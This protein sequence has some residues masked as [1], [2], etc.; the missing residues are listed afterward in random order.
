MP[1][2]DR[3]LSPPSFAGRVRGRIVLRTTFAILGWSGLLGLLIG[4]V[5]L[6]LA[7]GIQRE[8]IEAHLNQSLISVERSAA[9]AAFVS[10]RTLAREVV[11][12]LA[13][14]P[15]VARI[16]IR[17]GDE[18]LAETGRAG[19][20]ASPLVRP[21]KSPFDDAEVIG[22]ITLDPDADE[23][24]R[25]ARS[26]AAAFALLL[27]GQVASLAMVVAWVVQRRVTR[28]I[29][30]I[31][32]ELHQLDIERAAL[33][34]APAGSEDDEIGRL[35]GDI[36]ALAARLHGRNAILGAI[37][38]RAVDAI[39]LIDASTGRFVEF[40]DAAC[41]MT[42]YPRE[43]FAALDF[44]AVDQ[45]PDCLRRRIDALAPDEGVEYETRWR[46]HDGQPLDVRVALRRIEVGERSYLL[47][48]ASDIRERKRAQDALRLDRDLLQNMV[49]AQTADLRRAKEAA[50]AASSAKSVFLANMS[51]ELRTPMHAILSFARLGCDRA[52]SAGPDKL[53]RYFESIVTGG[54]RLLGLLNDLLDLSKLEAGRMELALAE[55]DLA[56]VVGAAVAEFRP[57]GAERRIAVAFER[58]IDRAPLR[59]DAQRLQQVLANL[60][61]NAIKFSPAAAQVRVRLAESRGEDGRGDG[62]F[63]VEIRDQGPG[64]PDGELEAV[65]EKFVQSSTTRTGA[66][67]TGLGLPIAREIARLH[68]GNLHASNLAGC[69]ACFTLRLPGAGLKSGDGPP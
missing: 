34:S 31:S 68:G 50:E 4:A 65:F 43:A 54:E 33:L 28:P 44:V 26:Y 59:C 36:N 22:T 2:Q 63:V 66:G 12:G 8:Q 64:I 42:G 20:V 17:A 47:A 37:V 10:D 9:V 7:E 62:N 16:A 61:S 21:L 60:L 3:P 1:E 41:A 19:G 40:N 55:H 58:E 11:G 23:I 39:C 46:M 18:M 14:N 56:A 35:A 48:I 57:L 67:G 38:S 27:G 52:A 13:Q 30:R 49:D 15:A 29:K 25:Q 32:D 24:R 6:V 45:K 5:S 69:G 53:A 51:H